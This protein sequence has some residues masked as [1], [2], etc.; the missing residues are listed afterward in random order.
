M[1]QLKE[2]WR[3]PETESKVEAL[4][5]TVAENLFTWPVLS[6]KEKWKRRIKKY[7]LFRNVPP[8]DPYY[9]PN[10]LLAEGLSEGMKAGGDGRSAAPLKRYY[11]GWLQKG[12]PTYCLDNGANGMP[13]LDL[14]ELTGEKKY[15]EGAKR[16]AEFLE[17][18]KR[19]EQGNLPYRIRQG[20]HIYADG[21]GM[22]C[23]FLCRYGK[24]AGEEKLTELGEV[25]LIHFLEKGMDE[26]SGLPYHG[27][28]SRT[29]EKY[30]CIGWGRAVGWLMTGLIR[31]LPWLA[32]EDPGRCILQDRFRKLA[33]T[34]L[35]FQRRDGSFAWLVSA[36]EGPA[37]TSA[38][39]MI[40]CA[41]L[42]G[43]RDGILDKR[44]NEGVLRATEFVLSCVEDGGV[45]QCS[46]ECKGFGEYPQRYGSYPWSDGPALRLLGLLEGA[47][48]E[49]TGT[50]NPI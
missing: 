1:E 49:R 39:A 34:V 27:F 11:D 21:L 10:A 12:L 31:S 25:Q 32:E 40:A 35:G 15:W 38:T 16:L 42:E 9:W 6:R 14:Y 46:G 22:I 8:I 43:R 48:S 33:E 2:L 4:R 7:I 36:L 19:D 23:P 3:N 44:V 28:D 41:L 13:L 50:V 37:D 20:N 18:H 5:A 47:A 17:A 26:G 24:L 29:G 30:G 45:T